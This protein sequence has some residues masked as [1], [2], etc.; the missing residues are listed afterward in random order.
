MKLRSLFTTA[1]SS[2]LP[3]LAAA[4]AGTAKPNIIILHADD[5]GSVIPPQGCDRRGWLLK[6]PPIKP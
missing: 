6:L 5:L 4:T 1:L 3:L 2:A